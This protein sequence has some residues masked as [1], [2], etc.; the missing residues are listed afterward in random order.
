[1]L[2]DIVI[3]TNVLM[4]ASNPNSGRQSE[5]FALLQAILSKSTELCLDTDS[6][7]RPGSSFIENEYA[8]RLDSQTVRQTVSQ[9]ATNG[10][11]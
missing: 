4:H 2:T 9:R 3:D 10:C 1:M 6:Q 5:A 8:A 11:T 7:G